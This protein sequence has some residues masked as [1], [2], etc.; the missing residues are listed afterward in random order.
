MTNMNV[1]VED[2]LKDPK[3]RAYLGLDDEVK[4]QSMNSYSNSFLEKLSNVTS[5]AK[6]YI[7]DRSHKTTKYVKDNKKKVAV[8]DDN[9]GSR[10]NLR[11]C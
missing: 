6:D 2:Y 7:V 10:Y 8:G 11:T 4:V 9:N 1:T 5:R 3:V